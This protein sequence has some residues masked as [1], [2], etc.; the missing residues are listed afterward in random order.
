MNPDYRCREAL[1]QM[2][3]EAVRT[4]SPDLRE[5]GF[6]CGK[7]RLLAL[8]QR[9][10]AARK[11]AA[12]RAARKALKKDWKSTDPTANLGASESLFK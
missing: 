7:F 10:A 4:A 12:T 11:G 3:I 8:K 9:A 6:F 5:F 1:R 2:L